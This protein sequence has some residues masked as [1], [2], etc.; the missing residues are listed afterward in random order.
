MC[1]PN[2]FGYLFIEICDIRIYV[3]IISCPFYDICLQLTPP[4]FNGDILCERPLMRK[5]LVLNN[6][7]NLKK[8]IVLKNCVNQLLAGKKVFS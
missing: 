4:S 7:H 1:N 8:K 3:D 6:S 2:T 5:D